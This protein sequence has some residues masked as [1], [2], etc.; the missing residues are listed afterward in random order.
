MLL[1]CIALSFQVAQAV[2]CLAVLCQV[3]LHSTVNNRRSGVAGLAVEP[4]VLLRLHA[5]EEVWQGKSS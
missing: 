1:Q 5:T 3:I 4:C 2:L